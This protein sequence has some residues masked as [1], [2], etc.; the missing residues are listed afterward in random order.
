MGI[1][2]CSL[3]FIFIFIF[4]HYYRQ[5]CETCVDDVTRVVNAYHHQDFIDFWETYLEG[6]AFCKNPELGFTEEQILECDG[7][8]KQFIGPAF[9][10]LRKILT[11]GAPQICTDIFECPDDHPNLPPDFIYSWQLKSPSDREKEILFSFL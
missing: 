7:N 4:L 10:V 6:Q 5:G 1:V 2:C 8:V 9:F 11:N 3:I